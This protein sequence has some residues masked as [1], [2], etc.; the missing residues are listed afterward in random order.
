MLNT[1]LGDQNL[2]N[3]DFLSIKS[4]KKFKFVKT[5]FIG[6]KQIKWKLARARKSIYESNS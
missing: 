4:K 2:S 5:A 1:D 6:D 3:L